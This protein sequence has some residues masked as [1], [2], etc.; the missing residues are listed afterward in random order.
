[1]RKPPWSG[2]RIRIQMQGVLDPNQDCSR[3]PILTHCANSLLVRKQINFLWPIRIPRANKASLAASQ[4]LAPCKETTR[5]RHICG[6]G[7]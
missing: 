7:L 6:P 4:A 1:M 3:I 2:H 5:Q